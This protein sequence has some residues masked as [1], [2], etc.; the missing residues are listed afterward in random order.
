[1]IVPSRPIRL[2]RLAACMMLIVAAGCSP[3][4]E[5]N[6]FALASQATMDKAA[7]PD[8]YGHF[9]FCSDSAIVYNDGGRMLRDFEYDCSPDTVADTIL[10]NAY[11][12]MST[13]FAALAKLADSKTA[14]KT[15]PLNGVVTAGTYGSLTITSTEAGIFAGLTA[16]AQ[17]LLTN[18]YKSKKIKEVL[19]T[20]HDT[21]DW[22]LGTLMLLTHNFR[23][24]VQLLANTYRKKMDFLVDKTD[25]P[26][27][28]LV[29]VTLYRDKTTKWMQIESD[30]DRRNSALEKIREGHEA[31]FKGVDNLREQNL[32]KKVLGLAQNIIYLSQ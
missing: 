31:L 17:D 9:C 4:K 24:R 10:R 16:A 2:A 15:A 19:R 8:A 32:K 29:L 13:Y 28:R 1:M 22:V 7:A 25:S 23:D 27:L 11:N 26:G 6:T 3:L 12:I 20:Y 5:V 18:N 14:I 30:Y 21:V